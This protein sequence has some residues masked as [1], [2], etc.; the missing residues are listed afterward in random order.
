MLLLVVS[1]LD[2]YYENNKTFDFAVFRLRAA[3]VLLVGMRGLGAEVAKN[4]VLAG[5]K[6][7]T[8]L[9]PTVVS[10]WIMVKLLVKLQ[11]MSMSSMTELPLPVAKGGVAL[12]QVHWS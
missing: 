7:L 11:L 10:L 5:I 1:L 3:S 4:I 9:D 8:L 2:S 6:S 12:K